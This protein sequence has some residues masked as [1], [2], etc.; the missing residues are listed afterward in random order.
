MDSP[1][2]CR[3][4]LKVGTRVVRSGNSGGLVVPVIELMS[5]CVPT[6]M[7]IE[8]RHEQF[9]IAVSA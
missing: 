5:D 2:L 1:E 9:G 3:F 4:T 7:E 6:R 8:Q